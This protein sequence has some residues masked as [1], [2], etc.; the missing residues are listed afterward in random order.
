M[1]RR[2]AARKRDPVTGR[3]VTFEPT[4]EQRKLVEGLAG[5]GCTREEIVQCIPWGTPD[6]TPIDAKTLRKHF[7]AELSRGDALAA[8]HL[9][10]T[11]YEM[12][13]GGDKTMLIFLLKVRC[14]WKE[15]VALEHAGPDGRPLAAPAQPMCYLPAK[16]GAREGLPVRV[17]ARPAANNAE[18]DQSLALPL[19]RVAP[20][21]D[22]PSRDTPSGDPHSAD[23]PAAVGRIGSGHWY[24]PAAD[25]LRPRR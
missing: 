13:Q 18:A 19:A 20:S 10:K 2:I 6:A 8:M 5:V 15:T 3:V 11:A 7:A 12:A 21:E 16:D 1:T 9:K 25:P 17:E 4:I 14:G 24:P 23:L 22:T